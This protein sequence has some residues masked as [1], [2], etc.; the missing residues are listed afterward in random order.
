M[1]VNSST[2]MHKSNKM[3]KTNEIRIVD[4][5]KLAKAVSG[6]RIGAPAASV[7]KETDK[8]DKQNYMVRKVINA[9]VNKDEGDISGN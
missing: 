1:G 3:S 9:E 4:D 7:N 2:K 8:T 5:K 6:V